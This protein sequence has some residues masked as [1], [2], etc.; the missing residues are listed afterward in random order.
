MGRFDK[1]V[2]VVTG[3]ASGL[4]RAYTERLVREGAMVL[5]LDIA[6]LD[7]FDGDAGGAIVTMTCD[8]S[9][10]AQV[11]QA[12]DAARSR[13]G[14]I[15]LLFNNAGIGLGGTPLH[16]L[17]MAEYDRVMGVN[18]RG[19]FMVM[20]QGIAAILETGRGGAIVNT[21]STTGLRPNPLNGA[22]GAA[23]AALMLM[24]RQAAIEYAAKGIR[25]NAVV[26]GL[27]KTPM[28]SGVDSAKLEMIAATIP[29][30]RAGTPEDVAAAALF[31]ASDDAAYVT[32]VCHAVD[33][34]Y[35][36]G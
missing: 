35:L 10:E 7:S 33:G 15:D 26:P 6:G 24:T 31:L 3:A 21:G 28:L 34:G 27:I 8:V 9:D 2:A 14:G 17:E 20:K 36:A 1:R 5:A 25:V 11:A 18:A 29:L 30:G 22:Y 12:F 19:A 23:K 4:G 32:G 13:W 16:L